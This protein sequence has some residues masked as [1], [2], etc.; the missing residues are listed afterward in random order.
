MQLSPRGKFNF[1]YFSFFG[2]NAVFISR[3]YFIFSFM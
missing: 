1:I 2:L 3:N